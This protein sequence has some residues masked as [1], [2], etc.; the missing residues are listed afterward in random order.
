MGGLSLLLLATL[1]A[2][3]AYFAY[4]KLWLPL[5]YVTGI[6]TVLFPLILS[7][8]VIVISK[9]QWKKPDTK[10]LIIFFP[11]FLVCSLY[12]HYEYLGSFENFKKR[13]PPL[14][15]K[16]YAERYFDSFL[17]L[18]S[19]NLALMVIPLWTS[20]GQSESKIVDTFS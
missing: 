3:A 15:N 7:G 10:M 16:G 12:F 18:C 8:Y 14:L 13:P 1:N 9:H 11:I 2:V 20:W 5:D 6:R 19:V 17:W 4:E